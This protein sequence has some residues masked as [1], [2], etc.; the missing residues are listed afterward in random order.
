M[1]TW[2]GFASLAAATRDFWGEPVERGEDRQAKEQ[3][4]RKK[5]DAMIELDDGRGKDSTKDYVR[6]QLCHPFVCDCLSMG[7]DRS[8]NIGV[9]RQSRQYL[10]GDFQVP[11]G[12]T[13]T[14]LINN[15]NG[16]V[17]LP[18]GNPAYLT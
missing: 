6:N 15:M 3:E 14:I 12:L 16:P 5:I 10:S 1:R 13:A 4:R 8:I 11:F 17:N 2:V 9:C 7:Y 18:R